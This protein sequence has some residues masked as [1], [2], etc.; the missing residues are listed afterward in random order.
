V[1]AK[2]G[3]ADVQAMAPVRSI[4]ALT[5]ASKVATTVGSGASSAHFTTEVLVCKVNGANLAFQELHVVLEHLS[6]L[7][8]IMVVA[9]AMNSMA[10]SHAIV[11]RCFAV[12]TLHLAGGVIIPATFAIALGAVAAGCAVA[13]S[14]GCSCSGV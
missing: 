6:K 1:G 5:T 10:A 12:M 8:W 2:D 3:V 9:A 4:T 7:H 13:D 11:A 14:G